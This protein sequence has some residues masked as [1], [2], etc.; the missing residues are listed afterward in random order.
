[1]K[2]N[3]FKLAYCHLHLHSDTAVKTVA[4]LPEL[5]LALMSLQLT[6]SGAPGPYK[7]SV[8]SETICNLTTAIK[9]NKICNPMMLF[10]RNQHLVPPP[11][12]L[13]DLIPFIDGLKLIV[14]IDIDPQ[15][16]IDDYI[17]NLISVVVDVEGIDNLVQCNCAPLLAFDTCS[18]PLHGNKPIPRET[19]EARNKL[20]SDA[21][22]EEQKIILGWL[23]NFCQLLICLPENKFIVWL[24]AISKMIKDR[25]STAKEIK[26]NLGRL[27]HLGLDIPSVHHFMS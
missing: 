24:E 7:W 22:L 14:V 18:H 26:T 2:K 5:E 3:D 27:V 10:R 13:D 11:K 25:V 17:S 6:F 15:G 4:Q 1:V 21:L 19:M 9:H 20:K 23:I 16:T 8:I 12:F